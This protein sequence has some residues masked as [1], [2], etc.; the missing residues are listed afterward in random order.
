MSGAIFPVLGPLLVLSGV[1]PL[2]ALL[3]RLALV[4]TDKWLPATW[5]HL[6]L[7]ARYFFVVMA[8]AAP[9]L[10]FVSAS[11]HQAESGTA[12][13]VCAIK[14][15]DGDPFCLE[16]WLFALVLTLY[17]AAFALQRLCYERSQLRGGST[18]NPHAEARVDALIDATPALH[19][20]QG[21]C[22]VKNEL[23]V[24]AATVG[25]LAP[26][27]VLRTDF[28]EQLGDDA[29]VGLLHHELVHVR[30]RDPLRS[31]LAA[32]ALRAN[33][34]ANKLWAREMWQWRFQRELYCDR[35]AVANGGKPTAIA[36]AIVVAAKRSLE[37]SVVPIVEADA[38]AIELRVELL[39]DYAER[40]PLRSERRNAFAVVVFAAIALAVLPHVGCTDALDIIHMAIETTLLALT[41]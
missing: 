5:Y 19:G 24:S 36:Q 23:P 20:L 15:E 29:L 37:C 39:L 41:S 4:L 28:V 1:L 10:W 8:S 11:L 35:E 25:M 12:S 32:W 16:P 3:T 13:S 38:H 17:F 2:T 26:R 21:R 22:Q 27:I 31:F 40:P 7:E 33:P 30:G 6:Q 18:C 9:L 14:H 34:W